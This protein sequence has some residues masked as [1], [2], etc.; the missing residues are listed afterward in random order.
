[1]QSVSIGLGKKFQLKTDKI[2]ETTPGPIYKAEYVGSIKQKL[3]TTDERIN[4][5]FGCDKEQ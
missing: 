4:S 5:T 2:D 3:D 1:M